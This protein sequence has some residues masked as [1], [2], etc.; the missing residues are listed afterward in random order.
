MGSSVSS[1]RAFSQGGITVSKRRSRLK[2]DI[3]E[4]LQVVKC[5]IR[6][7]LIF[8]EP[9]PCSTME[10]EL[11]DS[12]SE[13][14]ELESHSNEIEVWDELLDDTIFDDPDNMDVL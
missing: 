5:V 1:E 7:D 12:S 10:Q 4:G 14:A 9:A 8:R 3:V 13:G 6:K 11:H 2:G